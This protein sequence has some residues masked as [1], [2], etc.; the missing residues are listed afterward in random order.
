MK[1]LRFLL[2][3]GV[4]S[5]LAAGCRPG[6]GSPVH[7][8]AGQPDLQQYTAQAAMEIYGTEPER[9]LA[10]IDSAQIL[11]S[12]NPFLADFLRAKVYANSEEPQP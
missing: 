6:D 9:A 12:V 4:L 5:L 7:A 8:G 2:F 10:I 1:K 11:G 3:A